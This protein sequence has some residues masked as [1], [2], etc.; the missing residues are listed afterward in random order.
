MIVNRKINK[1]LFLILVR[2]I[3]PNG[4]AVE[5]VCISWRRPAGERIP[6]IGVVQLSEAGQDGY[7]AIFANPA[8]DKSRFWL[9]PPIERKSRE[10]IEV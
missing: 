5:G 10:M 9:N 2:I 8:K 7:G 4:T 3:V 6:R 1:V